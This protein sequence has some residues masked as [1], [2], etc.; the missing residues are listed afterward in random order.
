MRPH[1][2]PDGPMMPLDNE[3]AERRLAEIR[4]VH[5]FTTSTALT[6]PGYETP[7][8]DILM[9]LCTSS[10]VLTTCQN[11]RSSRFQSLDEGS[12]RHGTT[13]SSTSLRT[14]SNNRPPHVAHNVGLDTIQASG[15][16]H[17]VSSLPRRLPPSPPE[18][19]FPIIDRQR[20][21]SM[22]NNNDATRSSLRRS[23]RSKLYAIH[24]TPRLAAN[25]TLFRIRV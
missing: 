13:I 21:L 1:G 9:L 2:L 23:F 22:F 3:C 11:A 12:T 15:I 16:S 4:L 24:F 20:R 25:D 5:H 7:P 18:R 17:S 10:I 14:S 6:L 8:L 19:H